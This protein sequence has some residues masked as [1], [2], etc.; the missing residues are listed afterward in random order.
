MS[1]YKPLNC[2]RNLLLRPTVLI[3]LRVA[4]T[5]NP[6][7]MQA[8]LGGRSICI[9]SPASAATYRYVVGSLTKTRRRF[10]SQV[11]IVLNQSLNQ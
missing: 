8:L 11:N 9:G 2:L 10:E 6:A 5:T 1:D 3:Q 7:E 4:Y